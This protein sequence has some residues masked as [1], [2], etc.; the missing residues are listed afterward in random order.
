MGVLVRPIRTRRRTARFVSYQRSPVGVYTQVPGSTT[1]STRTKASSLISTQF[2]IRPS[3]PS[4]F[5][6]LYQID[7]ICYVPGIAYSRRELRLNARLPNAETLVA[8]SFDKNTIAGFIMSA[9]H[10]TEGRIITIDVLPEFRRLHVGTLLLTEAE[11][12]LRAAGATEI[13]LETAIN[14]DPAIAFWTKHGYLLEGIIKNYY[15][16]PLSAYAMI[17]SLHK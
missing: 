5:E 12:H 4:D 13:L 3:R 1:T 6:S 14:N 7:Q 16:G 11:T 15:P 17:K 10:R 8:A 9:R 2:H